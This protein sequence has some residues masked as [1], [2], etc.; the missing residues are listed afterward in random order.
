[1]S[2]EAV[3]LSWPEQRAILKRVEANPPVLFVPIVKRVT[4]GPR[5]FLRFEYHM[6]ANPNFPSPTGGLA[7][8]G[9]T[10]Y[11]DIIP[12]CLPL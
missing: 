6:V 7:E 5:S 4:D 9:A 3:D 12:E 1:M 10:I 8:V 2:F 11:Y